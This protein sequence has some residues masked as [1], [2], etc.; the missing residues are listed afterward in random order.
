M[1]GH[2]TSRDKITVPPRDWTQGNPIRNLWNLSW[3]AIITQMLYVLGVVIDLV[4]I[5]R[6]GTA[7]TAGVGIAGIIVT[8][9]A[10]GI[11]GLGTGVRAVVARFVGAGD[12]EKAQHAAQQAVLV[13]AIYGVILAA[14]GFFLA[15]SIM[16]IFGAQPEVITQGANYLRVW[17]FAW[18]PMSLYT[19][20]FSIMQ[21]SG[22]TVSPMRIIILTRGLHVLLA[23]VLIFGWWIFPRLGVSGAALTSVIT[24]SL[25]MTLT[26][27]TLTNRRSRLKLTLR[28]FRVDFSGIKRILAIGTPASIMGAQ[29]SLSNL[30]L[31]WFMVPF[32][33]AAVA[34]HSLI[35]R[36]DMIL[37]MVTT[38]VGIGSGIIIGQY[39]GANQSE[40]AG[41]SGWLAVG[42]GTSI[43]LILSS[44]LFI[45]AERIVGLLTSAP[46]LVSLAS[47]FLRIAA[48]GYLVQSF[49]GVLQGSISGA[50]DT[51]PPMFFSIA[52]TWLVQVP[53]TFFL[54]R[55]TEFGVYGVRWAMIASVVVGAIVFVIYYGSGR[56][57]HK[58]F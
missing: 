1:T 13:S 25:A 31:A 51:M 12:I 3:P 58:R 14:F 39:L 47:V 30:V 52:M 55:S 44:V 22:D 45:W 24:L 19:M 37:G 49:S 36:V 41:K 38:G 50:G 21:A 57:K 35:G 28:R 15:H 11:S 2:P 54:T 7:P 5:A 18:I 43:M 26:F 29:R 42:L 23:P 9:V 4:Y 53:L 33:S 56:W 10:A 16:G 20:N 8:V 27:M 17:A 6:L 46:D 34:A 48:V 40:K 32:G